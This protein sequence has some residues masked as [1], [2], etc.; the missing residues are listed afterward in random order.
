MSNSNIALMKKFIFTLILLSFFTR[1]L[2]QSQNQNY[3]KTTKYLERVLVED[4]F[5][6]SFGGWL[7]NGSVNLSIE[8]GMVKADVNSQWEG[9]K[10]NLE[11][12]TTTAGETLYIKVV[13]VKGNTQSNVRLYLPEYDPSGNW[14][15]W[16]TL[17]NNLET[18]THFYSLHMNNTGNTL[19]FRVDKDNTNTSSNTHFYIDYVSLKQGGSPTEIEKIENITYL[20]G[21][22]KAKQ[23]IGVKQTPDQKDI[24][25]HIEYDE[26]GRSSKQYLSVPTTQNSG[27]YVTN[28]VTQINS[29]YQTHFSDQHPFSETRFDDSPLSR[30]KE[31]STPGNTWELLQ[32]SDTDHTTKFERGVNGLEEVFK[33][34]IDENNVAS[35][36]IRSYY[37]E[38]ELLNIITKNVNWQPSDGVL[39]TKETFIDKNG[40][41]IAEF[42]YE[43]DNGTP[44]KL[45]TYYV[46][47]DLGNLRYVL[48]PKLF[49]NLLTVSNYNANWPVN[50]FLATGDAG[51]SNVYF[52]INNNII[53]VSANNKKGLIQDKTLH[54]QTTKTLSTSIPLPDMYLGEVMGIVDFAGSEA[55]VQ[56]GDAEIV[57]G[58]FK[59]SRTYTNAFKRISI[60]ITKPLLE[61][62][63]SQQ[64]LD[65]L[66]F[67][68]K[69]D[70]FNRQ[71]EQKVPGKGWEYMVYDQLDRP[72][73]TQDANLRAQ[74]KWLFNK[75]DVFGRVV[76]GGKY[77]N[78]ASRPALQNQVD[79]FINA[80]SNKANVVSRTGS[81]NNIGGALINYT[82]NA[83]P[84]S[85]QET[86]TVSY[87]D[88]YNF[89]DSNLPTIPSQILGQEVTN[90]TKGLLTATWTKTLGSTT[91]SKNYTFYDKKGRIIYA[92]DKNHLGGFTENKSKLDFRGKIE[93]SI[94]THKR[95]SS[96]VALNIEDTF[97][98]DHAERPLKHY[99]KINSQSQE[100]IANNSY[101]ELGQIETKNVG[102]TDSGNLQS[103]DYTYNMR[104]WLTNINDVN[105]LG[106]DLFAY[107]LKYDEAIEGSASVNNIYNG[108]IKQVIWR[109]A[110][111]NTKKSYAFEYDKLNRFKSSIYRENNSLTGGAGKFETY[112]LRYDA[113]GNIMSTSRNNQSGIQ[114]D[115]LGYTYDDGN[116]LLSIQDITNNVSGFND[117]YTAQLGSFEPYDYYY[118]A[119][120]NLIKDK[121]KNISLIEYNHLDLVERVTFNNGNKI[122]FDYNANGSKLRMR[123]IP[124]SGNTTTV[125]Y[126]G[127]FQ[128]TNNVLQHFSTPEG[129]VANDAGTYK[130]V[131]ILRDHLG[132]N[133]VSFSDTNL[134]GSINPA[135]EILSS[136]DHYVM[137]LTHPGEYIV[138]I[139]SNYNYKYQGKEKL[140][141]AG[142]NMYDFGSRMYDASV[143]R[144]FNTDPQNQFASPYIA[145]GNNWVM[146]VDHNGE[147]AWVPVIIGAVVGAY[148]GGMIANNGE[149]NPFKWKWDLKTFGYVVGGGIVGGVSGGIG[150][151]VA[152]GGGIMANTMGM[153]SGSFVNSLGMSMLT[154]NNNMTVNFGVVSYN[155][156]N[157]DVGYLGE[158]GNKFIQDFG[159]AMGLIQ[160]ANDIMV[161]FNKSNVGDVELITNHTGVDDKFDLIGHSALVEPGTMSDNSIVS[162]GPGGDFSKNPFNSTWGD[163]KWYNHYA[164][165]VSP[166]R[167]TIKGINKAKIIR[168]G[169]NLS[170]NTPKYNVY[171]SS[172]VTH[173]SSALMRSGFINIGIHPYILAAQVYLRDIGVRS[174]YF[175][176]YFVNDFYNEGN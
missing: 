106:S 105:N 64:E 149:L 142:Y 46:Y 92:N 123:N 109:S 34:D 131:Y 148:S 157:G 128:Y 68:Y 122:E 23:N 3:V 45:S 52:S 165:N 169:S 37:T 81:A 77:T 30:V 17:E 89:T 130:Y 48:T 38:G 116:K 143:G 18:G 135:N 94:T 19:K 152:E 86:L 156:A 28:A 141:F 58:D 41:K 95:L 6:S 43:D 5:T 113:N 140:A 67:Q 32:S 79:N 75:Y 119:N 88:D 150:G 111:N 158:K 145:L 53:T 87:Y 137:G 61:N 118:D 21:L 13:F 91:W 168:Y 72:I 57:N 8:N 22:G 12:F 139:G 170:K 112:S 73:L 27:N 62:G 159:Y 60:F 55:T 153:A 90:R 99:Q 117:G 160:N 50:D 70:A 151:A 24:L 134:D 161:G 104:G 33:F 132:N 97:E 125:D 100:L 4:S 2:A 96:S 42:N 108:N 121:N 83:F 173:T 54:P 78:S 63:F 102:G 164:D 167:N 69:Y 126:L 44:K 65:D 154:G 103:I 114:M 129:Y 11:G 10:H 85:N 26:F 16:N 136:T 110:Q 147:I 172:C 15:S 14:V 162:F 101:N 25:Q 163:P 76:Y 47:D 120:G 56:I 133:R 29:Y 1:V 9:V 176:N 80:S 107:R 84:N 115:K 82:N 36:L 20:D 175:N 166:W 35:P 98:Y 138:G 93:Q 7:P 146:M 71:I 174:I 31:T 59:I 155:F 124:T 127:G 51:I 74:N 171:F 66:A 40:R 49:D 144:W 39:N